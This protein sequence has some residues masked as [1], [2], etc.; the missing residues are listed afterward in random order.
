[1]SLRVVSLGD[2]TSC[3]E[4]VGL[5]VDPARTWPAR[6]A[7]ALPGGELLPLATA[8]ARVRDVRAQ[9]LAV[10]VE[11]RPHLATLLIGLNDV[12]RGGFCE[13]AVAEDLRV[14]VHELRLSGAT[15]LLGRLHDPC[16]HLPL[17]ATLRAAV[18][19]RVAVVNAA[20]DAA[21]A[22]AA[23]EGTGG[24]VHVLDLARMPALGLRRAWAVDRVHPHDAAHAL[25]AAEAARVLSDAGLPVDRVHAAGLP[26]HAPGVVQEVWWTARH[27]LPW[28]AAHARDVVLPAVRLAG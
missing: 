21:A 24:D 27:G 12:S 5:S 22:S 9:Q 3:G 1:M 19:G 14:V 2:S 28:L 10:A 18:R 20:V 16:R 26:Q 7:A 11:A 13:S 17:P 8:G 15:V 6:L 4:G 23:R 25:I